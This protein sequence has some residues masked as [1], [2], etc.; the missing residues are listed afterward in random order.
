MP[1]RI[2]VAV[3]LLALGASLAHAEKRVALVI[4]NGAYANVGA[5]PNPVRDAEAVEALLR[6]AGFDVVEMKRDV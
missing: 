6:G 2:A 5:L 4:G 3:F 1:L